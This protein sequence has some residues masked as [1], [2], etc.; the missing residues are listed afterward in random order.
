[1]I[2]GMQTMLFAGAENL[3]ALPPSFVEEFLT[4]NGAAVGN[5]TYE[6]MHRSYFELPA[7]AHGQGK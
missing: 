2:M 5:S 7:V 3:P 6:P 4:F 1:M